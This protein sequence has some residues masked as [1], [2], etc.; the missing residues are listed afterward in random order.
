[1]PYSSE[2]IPVITNSKIWSPSPPV[3]IYGDY[4]IHI[5]TISDSQY[6]IFTS[7]HVKISIRML[8]CFLVCI[9]RL[10][11]KAMEDDC[12]LNLREDEKLQNKY[13]TTIVNE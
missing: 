13:V 8:Y 1:M 12:K 10:Q 5:K 2:T 9:I 6:I 7:V 3:V 4:V 11:C